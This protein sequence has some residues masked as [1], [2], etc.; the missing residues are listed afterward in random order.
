ML[1]TPVLKILYYC[2]KSPLV[3]KNNLLTF[4]G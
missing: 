3:D 4:L 2:T 1:L